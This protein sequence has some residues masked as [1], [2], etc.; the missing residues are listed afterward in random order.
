MPEI[1]PSACVERGAELGDGVNIG[2]FCHVG[3]NV[4][5]AEGVRLVSH[6]VVAGRTTIGPNTHIYPFASIGHRPQDLKYEGEPS[7]LILGANNTIR[8]HVTMNPGTKGG[9]MVTRIGNNCLFMVSSHVAHDC[10]IGNHVIMANNATLAGH[11]VLE[12]YAILGGLAAVHQFCRIGRHAM[13]GGLSGVENDVI[14]YGSVLGNRARLAGLN[15]VG[16][17]RRGFSRADITA[18]RK[19]YRLMFAEEGTM[20]ERLEDVAEMY[21]DAEPVMEIVSFIRKVSNRAICQ[22]IAGHGG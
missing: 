17:K 9:G 1:H 21:K 16:L 14:P 10:L 2:P 22:P 3:S 12:D 15:I 8:E 5:L 18:L 11:V 4:R 20:A 13:V 6:V 19:A 7:E